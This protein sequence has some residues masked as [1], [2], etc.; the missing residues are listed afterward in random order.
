M[1][2]ASVD[3]TQRRHYEQAAA[4]YYSVTQI[5]REMTGGEAYGDQAA[6]DRGTDLHTIFAL[7]VASFAGRCAPPIVPAAYHG[8]YASM[9]QWITRAKPEPVRMEQPAVSPI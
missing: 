7:A 4:R 1:S 9:Q 5:C 6:M 8:Y 2:T 3:R